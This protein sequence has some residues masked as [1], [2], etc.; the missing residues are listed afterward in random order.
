MQPQFKYRRAI[1]GRKTDEIHDA[2]NSLLPRRGV[3]DEDARLSLNSMDKNRQ[4]LNEHYNQSFRHRRDTWDLKKARGAVDR[5][6]IEAILKLVLWIVGLGKFGTSSGLTSLHGTFSAKLISAFRTRGH[7][8]VGINEYYA[9]QK[10]PF[11]SPVGPSRKCDHGFVGRVNMPCQTPFLR[12]SMAAQNMVRAAQYRLF[13][14]IRPAE[15]QPLDSNGQPI[16]S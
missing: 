2:E 5:I 15:L 16:W 3:P 9:S 14:G 10:C 13:K 7:A 4:V 11:N 8:V 6:A 1:E 12:D